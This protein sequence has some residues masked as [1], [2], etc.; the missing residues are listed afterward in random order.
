MGRIAGIIA[1]SVDGVTQRTEGEFT[2]NLGTPLREA[3]VGNQGLDGYKETPQAAFIKGN[4][5][6]TKGFDLRAFME[7]TGVDAQLTL[8]TGE[9]IVF[10]DGFVAGEG[11]GSTDTAT[12]AFEFYANKGTVL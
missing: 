4:V 2:Y 3:L 12:I 9:V 10:T 5:R 8:S 11:T 1:L 6:V 7:K